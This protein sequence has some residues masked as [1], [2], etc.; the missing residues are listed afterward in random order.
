MD[1]CER[2]NA[3]KKIGIMGGTFNP[4]HIGH[5]L[6]AEHAYEQIGLDQVLF[7]P[8]KNPPH[9]R[10]HDLVSDVHRMNMVQLAIQDNPNFML[11]KLELEREGLTFTADTLSVMMKENNDTNYYFIVGAD[12]FFMMQNWKDPQIIFDLSTIVVAGRD[13]VEEERLEKQS[14]YLR[15]NFGASILLLRMPTIQIS[16]L[17]IRE[18]IVEKQTLRYYV[19]KDVISYIK[20]HQLYIDA[21]KE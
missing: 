13:H 7:M 17:N 1:S 3:M 11:S 8:S 19:P 9:K 21:V 20:Q 2:I 12:S 4:I 14:E 5:L 15:K 6:L 10:K 16:S 18:R